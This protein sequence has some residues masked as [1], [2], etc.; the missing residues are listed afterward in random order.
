MDAFI[1]QVEQRISKPEQIALLNKRVD[2]GQATGNEW[3]AL[4]FLEDEK[5]GY[6]PPSWTFDAYAAW[7]FDWCVENSATELK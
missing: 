7:L 3:G 1:E 6:I 2:Q 5:F 4:R